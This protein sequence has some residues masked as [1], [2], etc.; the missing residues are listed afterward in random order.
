MFQGQGCQMGTC[1]FKKESVVGE[2]VGMCEGVVAV[3]LH[4]WPGAR[5]G[6]QAISNSPGLV[7][8]I[9]PY[10]PQAPHYKKKT[11]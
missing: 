8:A 6:S 5:P 10:K 4:S 2:C 1:D 3:G 9:N 7:D 11:S